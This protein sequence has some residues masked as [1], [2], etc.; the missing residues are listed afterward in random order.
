MSEKEILNDWNS[1]PMRKPRLASVTINIGVGMSGEKL[2]KAL[3]VL[4]TVTGQKPVATLAKKSIRDFSIKAGERIGA[5][6]TLRGS[7]AEEFLKKA[8]DVVEYKLPAS[9]FDQYGNVA[10]GIKEHIEI[11]GAEYDPEIGIFGMDVCITIERPGYRIK[12]RRI[13][14]RK[15]PLSHRVTREEA[16]LFMKE[17]F[18]VKIE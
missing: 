8:L 1:N 14:R 15:I 10:F 7:K 18:G 11:P 9:H 4:E 3:T 12:R 16:M 2:N 17:R 6:V 5:K 13:F